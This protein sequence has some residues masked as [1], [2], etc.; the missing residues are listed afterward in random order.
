MDIARQEILV[1]AYLRDWVK[2]HPVE[3]AVGAGIAAGGVVIVIAGPIVAGPPQP[4]RR[5]GSQDND[6]PGLPTFPDRSP[7]R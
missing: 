4:G 6:P 7:R 2:K 5:P 3:T 1:G